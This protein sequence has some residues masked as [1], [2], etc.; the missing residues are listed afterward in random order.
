MK[1][2][3]QLQN[4][5]TIY[6]CAKPFPQALA[7]DIQLLT[8]DL[9]SKM[10][11]KR[12]NIS[13]FN[14]SE[15]FIVPD[16][17]VLNEE[18]K[19]KIAALCNKRIP[20]DKLIVCFMDA[21][22]GYGVFA[23]EEIPEGS[24]LFYGGVNT[25]THSF[26][27]YQIGFDDSSHLNALES[28]AH[29]SLFQDLY[30]NKAVMSDQ[31]SHVAQNNFISSEL[32]LSCGKL[33]Y[34]E[35]TT[36]IKVGKQCGASYGLIYWNIMH[37]DHGIN[38]EFFDTMGNRIEDEVITGYLRINS[39]TPQQVLAIKKQ[40]PIDKRKSRHSLELYSPINDYIRNVIYYAR[41]TDSFFKSISTKKLSTLFQAKPHPFDILLKY[42]LTTPVDAGIAFRKA[43]ALGNVSDM[44][45]LLAA[46]KID[47]NEQSTN[48][49]TALHW[50]YEYD[51][52]DS[53]TFLQS[54]PVKQDIK[55]DLDRVASMCA[56]VKRKA[57]TPS[58]G[59]KLSA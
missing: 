27:A 19:R 17:W 56:T 41:M 3:L 39:L 22:V 2:L 4:P 6:Y 5:T 40:L 28:G 12:R 30:S 13:H 26:S 46:Y 45:S 25:F 35:A 53:I 7:T 58:T 24:I 18:D 15:D 21:T 55:D 32:K 47:I 50:A 52:N 57:S 31:F 9:I 49:M 59:K 29:A 44:Q 36:T 42:K 8:P 34:Y 51:R 38:Q 33:T 20:S 43:S 48:K 54:L 10:M 37:I 1:A 14:W 16:D 23:R 11:A